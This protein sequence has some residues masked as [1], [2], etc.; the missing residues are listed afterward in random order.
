[1]IGIVLLVSIPLPVPSRGARACKHDCASQMR[2]VYL[3]AQMFAAENQNSL[4]RPPASARPVV[5]RESTPRAAQA[6]IGQADFRVGVLWRYL[7]GDGL[8]RS[9]IRCPSDGDERAHLGAPSP[10]RTAT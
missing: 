1:M 6:N 2:Q 4:P 9:L 7:P 5:R 8:R 10:A 3:F